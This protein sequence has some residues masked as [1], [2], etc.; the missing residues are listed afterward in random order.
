MVASRAHGLVIMCWLCGSIT[1]TWAGDNVLVV[2]ASRTHGLVIIMCWLCGS[3]TSHGLVIMC[4]LCDSITF[5]WVGDYVLVMWQGAAG[6]ARGVAT[7]FSSPWQ[8]H[9]PRYQAQRKGISTTARRRWTFPRLA[10]DL[11]MT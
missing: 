2:I 6:A 11:S 8:R 1:C 5:I 3:S 4:W 9:V 10:Y 7:D